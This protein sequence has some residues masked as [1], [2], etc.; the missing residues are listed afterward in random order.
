[1]RLMNVSNYEH[2]LKTYDDDFYIANFASTTF[3]MPT[4]HFHDGFEIYFALSDC[5]TC[6]V[7]NT[8]Y[9]VMSGDLLIF[10]N[11]DL[12]R[13]LVSPDTLY[14]RHVIQFNPEYIQDLSTPETDLLACFQ[15]RKETFCHL[16]HPLD[17]QAQNLLSL[18][19]KAEKYSGDPIYGQDVHRKIILAEILLYVNSLY[20]HA[21]PSPYHKQNK[22]FNR[23]QPVME[24]LNKHL[25]EKLTLDILAN[26]FFLSKYH[27]NYLFKQSTG[28]TINEYIIYQ[29]VF[30]AQEFLKK[31]MPV[32]TASEL[33]GYPNVSHFIR[34]FKKITGT[35]P[36]K[37]SK[38]HRLTTRMGPLQ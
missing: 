37:Y 24:Y 31:G 22:S 38:T 25:H 6:F 16:I 34:T 15:N 33:V 26:I 11:T 20:K 8:V 3:K 12:H 18:F 28:F 23:I 32:S 5:I 27:L 21:L 17:D 14:K 35:S 4:F 10:N 1:M 30:K 36:K 29:R 7:G 19:E 2:L 9:N 13:F